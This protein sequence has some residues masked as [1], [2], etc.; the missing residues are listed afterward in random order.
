M[1]RAGGCLIRGGSLGSSMVETK[2]DRPNWARYASVGVELTAAVAGFSLVGFWIDRH[3]DTKPWGVLIGAAL[4]ITGGMYNLICD[5]L[6]AFREDDRTKDDNQ[7]E[8]SPR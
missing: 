2:G 8:D 1:L 3:Y 5:S 7:R 4:G 6:A